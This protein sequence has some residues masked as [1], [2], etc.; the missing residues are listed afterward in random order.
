[1]LSARIFL[2]LSRHPSLSSIAFGRSSR[3]HPVSAQNCCM[4]GRAG[5]PVFARP[6]EGVHMSTSL[7]SSSLL[8]QQCSPCLV[9]LTLM[10]FVT[11]GSWLYSC[12]FWGA[13]PR[14]SSVLLSAFSCNCR[15]ASSPYVLLAFTW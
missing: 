2:T 12:C 9:R 10:V 5:C 13:V 7:T 1:M 8:L 15:K 6:C 3:L 14:T 11:G 4:Y